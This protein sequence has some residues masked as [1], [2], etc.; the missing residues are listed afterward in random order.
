MLQIINLSLSSYESQN[1][2]IHK[3]ICE[4][5]VLTHMAT[6]GQILRHH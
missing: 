1:I 4:T 2:K 6:A 5:N 3:S